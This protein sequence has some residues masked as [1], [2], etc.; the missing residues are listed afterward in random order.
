MWIDGEWRNIKTFRNEIYD[1]PTT[2]HTPEVRDKGAQAFY[3][4]RDNS[5][6]AERMLREALE[7][8]AVAG[9]DRPNR[10][11]RPR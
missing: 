9:L 1:E 11:W 6:E 7:Q 2:P 8:Q 10:S 4:I 5:A 3:L